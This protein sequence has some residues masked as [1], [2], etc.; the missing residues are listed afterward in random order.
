MSHH[1]DGHDD[2]PE[3]LVELE[4]DG[5]V[6]RLVAMGYSA[7]EAVALAEQFDEL[8]ADIEHRPM[9]APGGSVGAAAVGAAAVGAGAV[10]GGEAA[11]AAAG[12]VLRGWTDPSD[13]LSRARRR[14]AR[15]P[16]RARRV[17]A[18]G[19][20]VGLVAVLLVTALAAPS[21][22]AGF[23][24][25]EPPR[26]AQ[27]DEAVTPEPLAGPAAEQ[28]AGSAEEHVPT[29]GHV[30]ADSAAATVTVEPADAV[31]PTWT[32]FDE[33]IAVRAAD[34]AP[35]AGAAGQQ[36]SVDALGPA[37][38]D[39]LGVSGFAVEVS[40][41]PAGPAAPFALSA[42][43]EASAVAQG[44]V[45]L[46][47]S[48]DRSA[49]VELD[50][51]TVTGEMFVF[52]D[53]VEAD[54]DLD[55]VSFW[56]DDPA[57]AGTPVAVETAAPW[58]LAGGSAAEAAAFDTTTLSE[59]VHTL[60]VR[61][62]PGP[63]NPA[64][65][66]AYDLSATFTVDNAGV[67]RTDTIGVRL[68]ASPE[69][70]GDGPLAGQTVSGEVVVFVAT[71]E[72][73]AGESVRDVTFW[74]DD[75]TMTGPPTAFESL[76][77]WDL[78]G[79][80]NALAAWWDTS[81]LTNGEHTLTVLIDPVARAPY[82][83]TVSFTADNG[84][85]AASGEQVLDLSFDL[86]AIGDLAGGDWVDRAQ[87]WRLPDCAATT[88]ELP[89]CQVAEPMPTE[90][91]GSV[92]TSE[93]TT[94]APSG[95]SGAPAA[96]GSL[97]SP[98]GGESLS[99]AAGAGSGGGEESVGDVFTVTAG[100]SGPSGDFA[101]SSL[102][103]TSAWQAGGQNGAFAWSYPLPGPGAV[104]GPEPDVAL[105]YSSATVDG[106][107]SVTN[108]QASWVGDGFD[109]SMGFI[110][111]RYVA[112]ADDRDGGHPVPAGAGDLCW[113]GDNLHIAFEGMSGE[114]VKDDTTGHWRLK[115]DD[116]SR[117][118][119]VTGALSAGGSEESYWRITD[120][121]GTQY[122]FGLDTV[123]QAGHDAVGDTTALNSAWQVPVVSNHAGEP[124]H[125]GDYA[126]SWC[127]LT[128]RWNLAFV[129]DVHGDAMRVRYD[130][131]T[132]HY[133]RTNTTVAAYDRGGYPSEVHYGSRVATGGQPAVA[134]SARLSFTTGERC[135]PN[136]SDP[137]A[138][139]GDCGSR[140]LTQDPAYWP[141]TPADLICTSGEA[142]VGKTAPSFFTTRRL[143]SVSTAVRIGG[144]WTPIDTWELGHTFPES[145]ES[146]NLEAASPLGPALWLASISHTAHADPTASAGDPAATD[147][148]MPPVL[149]RGRQLPNRVDTGTDGFPPIYRYRLVQVETDTGAVIDVHYRGDPQRSGHATDGRYCTGDYARSVAAKDNVR[150]CYPVQWSFAGEQ[151]ATH[152]FHVYPVDRIEVGDRTSAAALT[153]TEVTSYDYRGDPTWA[154]TDSTLIDAEDRTF[155]DWRGYATVD[156]ITGSTTSIHGGQRT[157][158][159]TT[160]HL[161]ELDPD[162]SGPAAPAGEEHLQ[163]Y[164]LSEAT[165]LGVGGPLLE[166]T[167]YTP[168]S[169]V[170]ATRAATSDLDEA[171]AVLVATAAEETTTH[172]ETAGT[173]TT[174]GPVVHTT[175]V[176]T[177]YDTRM[178]P[179]W[180]TDHGDVAVAGDET[181]SATTYTDNPEAWLYDLIAET[182]AWSG[183]CPASPT[184][185]AL[186]ASTA[187]DLGGQRT[188]YDGATSH[189]ATPTQGLI[190][191][192]LVRDDATGTGQGPT[193]W[194]TDATTSYDPHGRVLTATDATG[195]TTTTT[196]TPAI[197]GPLTETTVTNDLGHA[198]T[199]QLEPR[200]GGAVSVSDPNGLVSE[201]VFDALGRV[202]SA[203][204]PDRPRADFPDSPSA[205][206]SY[207]IEATTPD[208]EG[209]DAVA[210][211]RSFTVAVG[212][213]TPRRDGSRQIAWR[214]LDGGLEPRQD[215]IQTECYSATCDPGQALMLVSSTTTD[216]RG[217]VVLD[218]G[219]WLAT[220][221]PGASMLAAPPVS[222]PNAA[223]PGDG[224]LPLQTTRT[225][226]GAGRIT[227]E[228]LSVNVDADPDTPELERRSWSTRTSYAGAATTVVPPAGAPATTTV[229]DAHG[230]PVQERTHLGGDPDPASAAVE[231]LSYAYS[232]RDELLSVTDHAG[233]TWRRDYDL[234]GRVVATTHPDAGTA[235]TAY[236]TSGRVASSTDARGVVTTPTYDALSRVTRTRA[237]VPDAGPTDPAPVLTTTTY[238]STADGSAWVGLAGQVTRV[239]DSVAYTQ[240]V[241]SVDGVGRPTST[242]VEVANDL[243]SG[244]PAVAGRVP[245]VLTGR[246]VTES[247]YDE[248]GYVL[249]Q[250]LPGVPGMPAETIR[251]DYTPAGQLLASQGD[252]A[253]LV[254]AAYS[255]YGELVMSTTAPVPDLASWAFTDYQPGTRALAGAQVYAGTR[256]DA[257]GAPVAVSD[258]SYARDEAGNLRVMTQGADGVAHTQCFDTDD[259]SRLV[260]AYTV[261]VTTAD[262]GRLAAGVGDCAS[263]AGGPVAAAARGTGGPA[264]YHLSYGFDAAG[265]R[266]SETDHLAGDGPAGQVTTWTWSYPEAGSSVG[267]GGAGSPGPHGA[268]S[269]ARTGAQPAAGVFEYSYDS[270]GNLT[271]RPSGIDPGDPATSQ[272][273]AWGADGRLDRVVVDAGGA[274]EATSSYDYGPTGSRML[275]I[276]GAR[277]GL[278]GSAE[279]TLYL[280]AT[281]LTA[282]PE[283]D[284]D[285]QGHE[286]AGTV[287]SRRYYPAGALSVL[288][289]STVDVTGAESDPG[290]GGAVDEDPALRVLAADHHGTTTVQI[291]ARRAGTADPAVNAVVG[292]EV[293]YRFL[294]PYGDP[295]T[296]TAND[297]THS[298]SG[299]LPGT[300]STGATGAGVVGTGRDAGPGW[301]GQRGFV[302]GTTDTPARE[303]GSGLTQIGYRAYDPQ[304]GAFTSTDPIIDP[305]SAAQLAGVYGYGHANPVTAA[306]PSG[307]EPRPIH[308]PRKRT[309]NKPSDFHAFYPGSYHQPDPPAS[310]QPRR[311]RRPTSS[312]RGGGGA[313]RPSI[314]IRAIEAA[315]TGRRGGGGVPVRRDRASTPPPP[316]WWDSAGSATTGFFRQG[317]AGHNF[318]GGAGSM[319]YGNVE[320]LAAGMQYLSFAGITQRLLFP[321]H[322]GILG[323][324]EQGRTHLA[325]AY[326]AD[327]DS[328]AYRTGLVAGLAVE[329]AIGSKGATT[330]TKGVL[331]WLKGLQHTPT[332]AVPAGAGGVGNAIKTVTHSGG[333]SV[334]TSRG[335]TFN[336]PPGWVGRTADNGQGWVYQRPGA[337]GNSDMIR[338]MDPTPKYP[339][340]YVRVHNSQGQPIGID[341]KPGTKADT[342][343]P[344]N[345]QGPWLGWPTQ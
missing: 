189:T 168:T 294:D 176:E 152:W 231:S 30:P 292:A 281:E 93:V 198:T 155:S 63:G 193:T 212:T 225:I 94:D 46:S 74:L 253:Y 8:A 195:A 85:A 164:V 287:T 320:L 123:A 41:A 129:V 20:G 220:G 228:T 196:Y 134:A 153:E 27:A 291:D 290:L 4:D 185:T 280:G 329:L 95:A 40:P 7:A 269:V 237:A 332:P 111:R 344:E 301:V 298:S 257:D 258:L 117:I 65:G 323:A 252:Y 322:T 308:N 154:W 317:G 31:D 178:R 342:H 79:G 68:S 262:A 270:A 333:T 64:G 125:A 72:E 131:E 157:R 113:R 142:C 337:A 316:R 215:Q 217:E 210:G 69:R 318:V 311:P 331:T 81:V 140:T 204:G 88:P 227:A 77:P 146:Q 145:G 240:A 216:A 13:V 206:F 284:T 239:E 89:E 96:G 247:V 35:A 42:G 175:R 102:S 213:S 109:L 170:T 133:R 119:H 2:W 107:T 187:T 73:A 43:P 97:L 28:V 345:Y 302:G 266:V 202:A 268:T 100:A 338:I 232:V 137:D 208:P 37:V 110:E 233:N 200:R 324:A 243:P 211:L 115:D 182:R 305:S 169:R 84:A 282:H 148:V 15:G 188:H 98:G 19:L 313:S 260:Q 328:T 17:A 293:T 127:Q 45:W 58:D 138:T 6:E 120:T 223:T 116:G 38:T 261:P 310:G 312:S 144:S 209:P 255:A 52:V 166:R 26:Q 162:G 251:Y 61:I 303:G 118:E 250:R 32:A 51:Q 321:E 47:T 1:H 163:G 334:T 264:P 76:A 172:D 267:A 135:T 190:T 235:T 341:G 130:T 156:T 306:D 149:L 249:R 21:A 177:S 181:C 343:I 314:S 106:R 191:Q 186:D 158:T 132:N 70:S 62:D 121:A 92:V 56:L 171:S 49:P 296:T 219:P 18:H 272:A 183:T 339:E 244:V 173:P 276:E 221:E 278:T 238:D 263:A 143:A 203:W 327:P 265:N 23:G 325:D 275:R 75:P 259:R 159:S 82:P 78:A 16:H 103:P 234:L 108:N 336:I 245:G 33:Q 83:V 229:V 114:L 197:G 192:T 297:P 122:Y 5:L 167:S 319:L 59:G 248:Q 80:E 11:A 295:L 101:A 99:T 87:V 104:A 91:S 174:P 54:A 161:G 340:G 180:E 25:L 24:A 218:Q 273:L 277:D 207:L 44:P 55:S 286:Q 150:H 22:A 29:E 288:R 242:W 222:G 151:A 335:N 139:V 226:D 112:C 299:L 39:A 184:I 205:A 50:G 236:D 9:S 71:A 194:R 66:D 309:R 304:S 283:V 271:S 57:G 160:Y 12:G 48:P 67:P 136:L 10:A 3:G 330:G 256:R 141:D 214:I 199:T 60:L 86:S 274:S 307:L 279:T 128:W 105:S 289:E 315:A 36:V 90:V 300:T 147:V 246:Y 14:F 53:P 241:D 201:T 224:A 326:G 179:T 165:Y 124:C 34:V 285:G 230:R 254:D 126:A